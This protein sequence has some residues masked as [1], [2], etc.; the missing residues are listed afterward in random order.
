MGGGG[1]GGACQ[2]NFTRH[3]FYKKFNKN[4]INILTSFEIFLLK[5]D[6]VLSQN[7]H[8]TS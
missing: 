6:A 8:A 2:F 3:F 7:G 4:K 1:G 5:I